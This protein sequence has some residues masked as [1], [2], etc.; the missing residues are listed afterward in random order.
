[1]KSN[2]MMNIASVLLILVLLT[3]CGL[4]K[5][6]AKYITQSSSND[7][8]RVAKWGVEVIVEGDSFSS[9]YE[10]DGDGIFLKDFDTDLDYINALENAEVL[11]MNY[12]AAVNN[13]VLAP[14]TQGNLCT[15]HIKG[16]PE[17]AIQVIP[18][19]TLTINGW[20]I[21]EEEYFP[22]VFKINDVSYKIGEGGITTIDQLITSVQQA[23]LDL[24]GTYAPNTT[25]DGLT[26]MGTPVTDL[27]IDW[28]WE[29]K[30]AVEDSY[31]TNEKDTAVQGLGTIDFDFSVQVVQVD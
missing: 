5:T 17:V 15:I 24:Q 31:R 7:E 6:Y 14:G 20:E 22:I 19:A 26:I 18:S 8:A 4:S 2:R 12:T 30:H 13:E 3:T 27:V 21:G 23:V 10:K 9:G 11:S 28:F 25:L 29:F 16:K 1:M